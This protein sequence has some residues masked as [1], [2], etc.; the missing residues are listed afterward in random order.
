MY[1]D[2]LPYFAALSILL[3]LHGFAMAGESPLPPT[4]RQTPTALI[5]ETAD[6]LLDELGN[7][8][9]NSRLI[10]LVDK[11]VVPHLD[12]PRIA[13]IVLGK[14]SRRVDKAQFAAFTDEFQ[15]LLVK[16]YASSL[17]RISGKDIQIMPAKYASNGTASVQMNVVRADERPVK[18]TFVTHN[19]N[20]PWLVYDI[21]IE[22]ISLVTNYRS[23]FANLIAQGGFDSLMEQL[24][25]RN[26]QPK[27]AAN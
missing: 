10:A 4:D 8:Y 24:R 1:R 19:R 16:T 22:G 15:A 27:L 18:V 7:E 25:S 12:M 20:G 26:R 11:T 14:Y 3:L 13:K 2:Y 6:H 23:E 5:K 9:D 21:R 17:Q